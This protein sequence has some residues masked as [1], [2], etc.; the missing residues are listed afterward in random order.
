MLCAKGQYRVVAVTP[1]EQGRGNL[2]SADF[3]ALE[4][5]ARAKLS[6]GAYAFAAAG[7]DDEITLAENISAWRR[8]RLRPHV[9]YDVAKIDTGG[10]ILGARLGSP[11]MVAPFGRHKL[12]HP[13]GERATARGAAAAGAVFV[14]PTTSTVSMEDVATEPATAPRWFQLYLPPDRALTENLID[15]A[16]AASFRAI[17]LTVDQPVYG[18]SPRAARAPIAPS[19]DIR[20]ANLPDQ[21]IAQHSYKAGHTGTVTFPATLRDL[22]W[23]V[24][25]SRLDVVVKG[26]LRGD[27]AVRCV[28]AGAKAIIVS[29]HGGRHLDGT[30]AAADALPEIADAVAGKAELYVDGGIRRGTDIVKALALGARAVL[31][32]RPVIW[33]LAL[34]GAEGVRAVLDHLNAELA[35]AMALCGAARLADIGAD[36]VANK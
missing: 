15:R 5:K 36:L 28:E 13:E 22:E 1:A 32:A 26:V 21:P 17:V 14:L 6:P 18:S 23:L 19:P 16:A 29:N 12:F 2:D 20:N 30:I 33:G 34:D 24:S 31:V 8:L 11:I 27:D 10:S 35:R 25:R 9:L 4:E 3:D 7:A